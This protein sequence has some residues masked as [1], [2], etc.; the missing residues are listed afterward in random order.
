ML[1]LF[2][3]HSRVGSEACSHREHASSCIQVPPKRSGGGS[4]AYISSVGGLVHQ[5]G[6]PNP[7][8]TAAKFVVRRLIKAAAVQFG[9]Q[10]ARVNSVHPG[11]VLPPMLRDTLPAATLEGPEAGRPAAAHGRPA[12]GLP[13]QGD[14]GECL[15]RPTAELTDSSGQ[16]PEVERRHDNDSASPHTT[17]PKG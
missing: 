9:P 8:Y 2:G 13:I 1:L 16:R 15:R 10:R 6:V 14:R 4:V 17:Q 3:H 7:A 11:G 12:G 5:I